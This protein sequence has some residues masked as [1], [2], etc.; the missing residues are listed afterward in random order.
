MIVAP[1]L[2]I[3]I[4]MGMIL[5]N[6]QGFTLIGLGIGILVEDLKKLKTTGK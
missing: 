2:F 1:C 4:G 3:G 6:V 5:G